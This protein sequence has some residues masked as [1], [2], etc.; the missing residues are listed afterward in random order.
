MA[1]RLS[2]RGASQLALPRPVVELATIVTSLGGV[3]AGKGSV[4]GTLPIARRGHRGLHALSGRSWPRPRDRGAIWSPFLRPTTD[5]LSGSGLLSSCSVVTPLNQGGRSLLARLSRGG[6]VSPS[7][8]AHTALARYE[9]VLR[10]LHRVI[11]EEGQV[12]S[13]GQQ[14]PRRCW[15]AGNSQAG[16]NVSENRQPVPAGHAIVGWRDRGRR[17][18]PSRAGP[19]C[20]LRWLVLR[21][22]DVYWHLLP[23]EL[24]LGI[25]GTGQSP[26]LP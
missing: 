1:G 22:R 9:A 12:L 24:F 15:Q 13:E 26:F 21:S 17:A 7:T 18:L 2:Y 10:E 14:D 4:V 11:R 6:P 25:T 8:S 3:G 5:C 19:R 16:N 20:P 23:T